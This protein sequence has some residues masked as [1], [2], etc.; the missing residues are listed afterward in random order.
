MLKWNQ[1]PVEKLTDKRLKQDVSGLVLVAKR[2]VVIHPHATLKANSE[3]LRQLCR[4]TVYR[5]VPLQCLR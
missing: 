3:K 1:R 2:R 4:T 5:R